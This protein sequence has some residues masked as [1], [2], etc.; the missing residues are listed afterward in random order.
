MF[1]NRDWEELAEMLDEEYFEPASEAGNVQMLNKMIGAG[2]SSNERGIPMTGQ[3]RITR[4]MGNR[5]PQRI[6]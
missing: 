1:R 2:A 3:E 4:G 6:Q 5:L